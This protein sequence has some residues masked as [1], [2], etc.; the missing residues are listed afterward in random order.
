MDT[1][2]SETEQATSD[3][4]IY[5][6]NTDHAQVAAAILATA[7]RIEGRARNRVIYN[8]DIE[9]LLAAIDAHPD[10]HQARRYSRDGFVANS[11]KYA[12]EITC[13]HATRM[14]D[15]S[16]MISVK[17]VGAKRSYGAGNLTTVD[18]KAL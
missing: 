3:Q 14:D 8:S 4:I 5:T 1:Q 10:C 6:P 18:G 17:R 11:Y 9:K 13:A 7:K 15:G 12:A 2:I 16:Y